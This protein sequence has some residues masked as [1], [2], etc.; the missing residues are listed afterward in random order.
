[1]LIKM[2]DLPIST[3]L[4]DRFLIQ[5]AWKDDPG[6]DVQAFW[7]RIGKRGPKTELFQEKLSSKLFL[8]DVQKS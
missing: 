8:P 2:D 1:M 4:T 6:E 7:K 5:A 3:D